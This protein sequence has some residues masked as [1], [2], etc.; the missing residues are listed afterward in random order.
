MPRTK[1]DLPDT[2]LYETTLDI[3]ITD[4]NYGGHLG[5]DRALSLLHEARVRFLRHYQFSELNIGGVGITMAD[6]VIVFKSESFAGET[7]TISIALDEPTPHSVAMFYKAVEKETRREVLR[8]KT[9]I[10]FF[11]Y[12]QKKIA[13]MPVVFREKFFPLT[14][15]PAV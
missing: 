13:S 3:R 14:L 5:N 4:I 11:D 12:T 2:F 15:K 6:A 8:A 9:G 1:L 7:L 10:V